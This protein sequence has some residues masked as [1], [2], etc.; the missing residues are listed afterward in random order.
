MKPYY[1]QSGVTIYHGDCREVLSGLTANVVVTDPPYG[2]GELSGTTAIARGK[3]RYQSDYFEDTEAYLSAVVVPA[4]GVALA[5]CGDRGAITPGVRCSWLYPRPRDVG[6]FYQPAAVGMGPWGFA[7]FNPVLFYGKDPWGGKKPSATMVPL[8][9]RP[10]DDGHPCAKPIGAMLWLVMKASIEGET[11]L[12]PF[13]GTGTTLVAAKNLNR[14]AIGIE[15]EER[16]CE[17][18]ARRL[19]QEVL[20]FDVA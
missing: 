17:I 14:C 6:G 4:V 8:T 9:E 2:L 20:D 19:S 12:D 7:S 16:Y 5:R 1:E 18:A 15:L 3:N 11:V 13:M 10:S